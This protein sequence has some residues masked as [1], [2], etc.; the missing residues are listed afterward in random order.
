MSFL[1]RALVI[2]GLLALVA[3]LPWLVG[4]AKLGPAVEI[5]DML[6]LATLWNLLAGYAGIV[7][8][9]QQA[10]VG[11]G[12]YVLFG[13][14]ILAGVPPLLA[15]PLAGV[16][17][18][19]VGL[20]VALLLFRLRGPQLAIGSWVVAEVFRLVASQFAALGGGSGQ[21]LPVAAVRGIAP[22]RATRQLLIYALAVL[23]A[24]AATGLA[25]AVLRSRQGLGLTAVRDNETAAAS[26]G[27]DV[28]RLKLAVYLAVSG[29]TGAV[30]AVIFLQNLRISPDA[31]FSVIEFTA[32]VIFIVVIGGIGTLEGPAAGTAVFFLFRYL[33]ADYG[34]AY[35]IALGAIAIAV[36][37]AAPMGLCGVLAARGIVLLPTSRRAPSGGATSLIPR[38]TLNIP[39]PP[40]KSNDAPVDAPPPG[41]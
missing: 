2:A 38:S 7:S 22:D 24:L 40:P 25:W 4:W 13:L 11:L 3:V 6:A 41:A 8:I 34:A 32:D 33:F 30:G 28:R 29:V 10:Y 39:P 9:G 5:A 35:L 19:A 31:G 12:G 16:V 23:L 26:L 37:L 1:V 27:V 21:S 20:P 15:V 36:M 17:S 14:V 18:F